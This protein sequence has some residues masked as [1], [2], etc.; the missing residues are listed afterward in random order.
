M[1]ISVVQPYHSKKDS[2]SAFF[3]FLFFY[4]TQSVV[5]QQ[6]DDATMRSSRSSSLRSSGTTNSSERWVP[7]LT[8]EIELKETLAYLQNVSPDAM[9]RMV[10]QK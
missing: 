8:D 6:S 5:D 1:C 9:F 3:N 4:I 10:L 7:P 2:Y